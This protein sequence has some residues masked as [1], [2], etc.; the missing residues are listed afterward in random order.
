MS[1]RRSRHKVSGAPEAS[2]PAR[3]KDTV[4]STWSGP[5]G[6]WQTLADLLGKSGLSRPATMQEALRN[7]A[8]LLACDVIAQDIGKATFRMFKKVDDD[9]REEVK[10]KDHPI[11]RMLAL[12]PNAYHT[13]ADFW[14]MTIR[15]FAATQ[16][17]FVAKRITYR[18]DLRALIP[19]IPSRVTTL[20]Y[21]QTGELFY[22]VAR[23][24]SF[25]E[26]IL[27][28]FG[29]R[30]RSEQ[31]L[32]IRG[33]L[34][35]GVNGYSTLAAG[36][37]SLDAAKAIS[38][39]QRNLFQQGA[40]QSVAFS[41]SEDAELSEPQFARLR[42][43]FREMLNKALSGESP[44]VLENGT[45]VQTLSMTAKDSEVAVAA[46]NAIS[47]VSRLFR[48]PPHKL[49]HFDAVK[50]ENMDAAERTYVSD[51]LV[52]TAKRI[53][54]AFARALLTEDERLE[55][56]FE[57]DRS[58]MAAVDVKTRAEIAKIGVQ[59]GALTLDEARRELGDYDPL[60]ND[61]GKVRAIPVNITLVDEKNDP[62]MEGQAGA[63][64]DNAGGGQS[65]DP[66]QQ[67]A[68]PPKEP[69]KL[70]LLKK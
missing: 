13:W 3:A 51:S 27:S 61:S 62:V 64:E 4:I 34:L 57:F 6:S 54:A 25:E 31:M 39:Y 60:P 7:S 12:D 35:D 37:D 8:F 69:A 43:Q 32:H 16:N 14:D 5:G 53:E 33:R 19:I 26:A 9:R 67:P 55:Y 63:P 40:R 2:V 10:P 20:V 36:A 17:A 58:E 23:S 50:Y 66:G 59:A 65:A 22:D 41:L 44:L 15:Y 52:P 68:T 42:S 45:T 29:P 30:L 11:S 18:G 38:D 48:M 1:R 46:K 21:K 28:D 70:L 47:E 24:N 56:C 49:M